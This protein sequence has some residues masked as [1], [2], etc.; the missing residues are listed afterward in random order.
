VSRSLVE[1]RAMIRESSGVGEV[2]VSESFGTDVSNGVK[3]QKISVDLG[4][5][6][7]KADNKT[8]GNKC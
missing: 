4:A 1:P 3:K 5:K 6:P 2:E 8:T 7:P